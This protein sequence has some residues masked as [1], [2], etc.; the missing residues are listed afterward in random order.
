MD[1]GESFGVFHPEVDGSCA[2]WETGI[3]RSLKAYKF[4][5]PIRTMI[6]DHCFS[7]GAI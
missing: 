6:D 1:F 5:L 7:C 2:S 4:T 3:L